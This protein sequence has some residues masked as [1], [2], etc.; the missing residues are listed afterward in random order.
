[1][2]FMTSIVYGIIIPTM[3][4]DTQR[5]AIT[6]VNGWLLVWNIGLVWG[7]DG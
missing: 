7:N 5:M 3:V 4:Y 2:A 1:M 6:I